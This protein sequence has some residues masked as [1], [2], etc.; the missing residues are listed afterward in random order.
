MSPSEAKHADG[1]VE[2]ALAGRGV[3]VEQA[4]LA[5]GGHRHADR[6]AD[7]LAERAGGGLDAD[8]V[9]VLRVAGGQAAP[10]PVELEVLERQAVAGQVELDVQRQARVPAREHEAVAADPVRD[11]SGRAAGTPGRSGRPRGQAHRGARGGRCRPPGR[12]PWPGPGCSRRLAGR[13]PR[14]SRCLRTCRQTVLWWSSR[15]QLLP[16]VSAMQVKRYSRRVT[17]RRATQRPAIDKSPVTTDH[18]VFTLI[19]LPPGF[20]FTT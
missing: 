14:T 19:G 2:D 17:V 7:A 15:G 3:G 11:R 20:A 10:L 9:A 4:A 12:R 13:G 5:A 8:G 18:S 1:V 16:S 6:V